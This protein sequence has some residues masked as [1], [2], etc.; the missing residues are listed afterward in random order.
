LHTGVVAAASISPFDHEI[1]IFGTVQ[2]YLVQVNAGGKWREDEDIKLL[3][4]DIF[5]PFA[6]KARSGP[7]VSSPQRQSKFT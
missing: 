7:A 5:S 6:V 4:S 3:I 1:R 2:V